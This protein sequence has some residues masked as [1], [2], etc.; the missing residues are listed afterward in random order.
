MFR[1]MVRA[2]PSQAN[3][4]IH[5]ESVA[6]CSCSIT[7]TKLSSRL[8]RLRCEMFNESTHGSSRDCFWKQFNKIITINIAVASTILNLTS[9]LW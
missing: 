4:S 5:I 1:S 6:I 2:M 7:V 9:L 8:S 3:R